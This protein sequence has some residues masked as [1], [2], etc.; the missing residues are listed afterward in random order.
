MRGRAT[1]H[2]YSFLLLVLSILAGPAGCGKWPDIVASSADIKA[3][4]PSTTAVRAR[5][6]PDKDI[7]ALAVLTELS[8]LD[9]WGGW[10]VKE[11]KTT[12]QGFRAL[13]EIELPHLSTLFCGHT[14]NITDEGLSYIATLQHVKMLG[15]IQ[16][17]RFTNKGLAKLLEKPELEYLDL[18]GSDWVTDDSLKILEGGKKLRTIMLNG[19]KNCTAAGLESLGKALP[20]CAIHREQE[21]DPSKW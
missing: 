12:D 8:D 15:L 20:Y 11:A 21:N 5:G 19:C 7:P 17:P 1:L 2:A 13:S 4:P 6:L 18:R 9:L 3:L 10:K 16:C 14:Q